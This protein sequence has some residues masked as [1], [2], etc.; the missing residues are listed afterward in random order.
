MLR[1]GRVVFGLGDQSELGCGR[2]EIVPACASGENG[3]LESVVWAGLTMIE[4]VAR[5]IDCSM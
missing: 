5:V 3:F 1:V 2:F 4:M